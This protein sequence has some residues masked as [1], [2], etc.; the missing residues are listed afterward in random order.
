[1]QPMTGQPDAHTASRNLDDGDRT[2][3][4]A[5]DDRARCEAEC[6]LLL[7]DERALDRE[8]L[9]RAIAGH[10][11][12]MNVVAL[13]SIDEWCQ[14]EELHA[15][16]GAV[17]VNLGARQLADG[18]AS[19]EIGQLAAR[20]RPVPVVVLADNDDLGQILMAL[21][22]GV[23]GY[24][25]SSVGVGVCAE[26]VALAMA[27]GIFV[28]AS[29]VMSVRHL[30]GGKSQA[31]RSMQEIFTHRQA[32]VADALRRG[33]A[34]KIIAYELNMC[35]STVKVH[36]RNIMKK[37]KATN[38]TEVAYKVNDLYR[39]GGTIAASA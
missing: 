7:I 4:P 14:E 32:E 16:L 12:K 27:G 30:I 19:E 29:S 38:R 10:N 36:V 39:N 34:N 17:L 1:M 25:P 20:L 28:P 21:E 5:H 8:C 31:D 22:S 6:T 33:K 13:G 37:L 26:A 9:A 15:P 35:E 3:A 23:R 18:K 24:I 2:A 11:L